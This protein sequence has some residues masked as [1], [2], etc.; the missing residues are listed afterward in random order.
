[1]ATKSEL[2]DLIDVNLADESNIIAIK[3]REVE[4]AFVNELYPELFIDTNLVPPQK[5][6]P[7]HEIVIGQ[8][9]NIKTFKSGGLVTISGFFNTNGLILFGDLFQIID[10]EFEGQSGV[11]FEFPTS[12]GIKNSGGNITGINSGMLILLNNKISII[13]FYPNNMTIYFNM[14]Y[15]AK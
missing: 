6:M 12:V 7:I 9:Y 14:T 15:K 10:E 3:H 13:N 2:E 5:I 1:M 8:N 4:H 11:Q